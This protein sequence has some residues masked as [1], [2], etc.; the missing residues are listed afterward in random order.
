MTIAQCCP[1]RFAHQQQSVASPPYSAAVDRSSLRWCPQ[2]ENCAG[3]R[4][5]KQANEHVRNAQAIKQ[6]NQHVVEKYGSPPSILTHPRLSWKCSIEIKTN[7]KIRARIRQRR[8]VHRRRDTVEACTAEAV[9]Q[10]RKQDWMLFLAAI[11]PCPNAMVFKIGR[12][13]R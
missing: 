8:G 9:S 11:V 13:N 7:Q 10:R 5:I 3:D 1:R 6:A 2:K 12:T 4:A